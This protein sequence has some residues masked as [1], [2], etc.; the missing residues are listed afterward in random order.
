MINV[1]CVKV[2][3]LRKKGY[4][5]LDQWMCDENNIYVGRRGRI[6][7]H[8]KDENGE[9]NKRYFG[10]ESSQFAN[11]FTL[12]KYTLSVSLMKYEE[13]LREKIE[14][15]EIDINIC[16]GKTIGCFCKMSEDLDCLDCHT[17]IIYK[18]YNEYK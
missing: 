13:Y 7:I 15:S 1:Q 5:N 18:L 9:K 16:S 17:K 12:K 2:S 11:P 3:E 14:N 10:Y 6:F 4:N 8:F